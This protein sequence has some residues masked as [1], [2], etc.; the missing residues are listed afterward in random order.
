MPPWPQLPW[1]K[2]TLCSLTKPSSAITSAVSSTKSR[3]W[4]QSA[5]PTKAPWPKS[6]AVIWSVPIK[7]RT[8]GRFA[9]SSA[10]SRI[11]QTLRSTIQA[12][13]PSTNG[14]QIRSVMLRHFVMKRKNAVTS[15]TSTIWPT[16]SSAGKRPRSMRDNTFSISAAP[17]GPTQ[18]TAGPL[19]WL[20]SQR[21][22][23]LVHAT[24]TNHQIFDASGPKSRRALFVVF[25]LTKRS[26]WLKTTSTSTT[27]CTHTII[28]SQFYNHHKTTPTQHT[29]M[30]TLYIVPFVQ[31]YTTHTLT[32]AEWIVFSYKSC[33]SSR[34]VW[35]FLKS[36]MTSIINF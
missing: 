34:T 27:I 32:T 23:L 28:K 3:A 8:Y 19:R 33:F 22:Q 11:I 13:Q 29:H 6:G 36:I 30:H 17:T 24:T 5:P 25:A 2:R 7:T 15:S 1:L 14:D 18:I 35:L 10:K 20:H 12:S 31:L 9:R 21:S 26:I 16:N 4:S